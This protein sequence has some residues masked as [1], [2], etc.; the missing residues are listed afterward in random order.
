MA[1]GSLMAASVSSET[2]EVFLLEDIFAVPGWD[3]P[4]GG[5]KP[6]HTTSAS[7]KRTGCSYI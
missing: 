7:T 3:Q 2:V 4:S 6:V 5:I 1:G